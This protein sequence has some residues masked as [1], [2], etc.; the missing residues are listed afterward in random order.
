MWCTKPVIFWLFAGSL[1]LPAARCQERSAN[2]TFDF[3]DVDLRAALDTLISRYHVPLLFVDADVEGKRISARCG[4]CSEEG[5]LEG[6]LG[7][8]DLTWRKMG[9]QYLIS[10]RRFVRA[11]ASVTVRGVVVD[12]LTGLPLENSIVFLAGTTVGASSGVNGSF[13]LRSVLAGG[14]DL[15][16]SV[17]GHDRKVVHLQPAAGDSVFMVIKLS[18]RLLQGEL[19]E[20]VAGEPKD[21]KKNLALFEKIFTGGGEYAGECRL[22]N[23][24]VVDL[25]LHGQTL[26]ATSDSLLWIDNPALGYTMGV[27]IRNFEWDVRRDQGIWSVYV[28]F[29][30]LDPG[31]RGQREKWLEHRRSVYEGS[32]RH[33][34]WALI[35]R[36][37][38]EEG[39]EIRTGK[40]TD[41]RMWTLI[42]EETIQ[43]AQDSKTHLIEWAY[44]KRIRV[45]YS[46]QLFAP[47]FLRL[48][49]DY[50][51]IDSSGVVVKPLTFE[52][53][54]R[55]GE[56][57]IGSVLP[58]D[59]TPEDHP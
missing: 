43:L 59:Y 21:W 19:V 42:G 26:V 36:R 46:S 13:L 4:G 5:A 57:R 6:V 56:E 11:N 28:F 45:D 41:S 52:L 20:V 14:M 7:Q 48:A 2:L 35:H 10:K 1:L 17:I 49:E 29:K 23:P 22:L 58:N 40:W 9:S 54:G 16:A 33:F 50:A 27:V 3:H 25:S 47:G 12:S 30:E 55:W 15:V 34:L 39:F 51:L 8:T 37:V 18:P 44:P 31:T 24:Y 32:L 53:G 38:F